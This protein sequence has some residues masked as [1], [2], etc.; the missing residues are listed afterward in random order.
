[1]R[2]LRAT[3]RENLHSNKDPA[4]SK[5]NIQILIIKKK[6]PMQSCDQGT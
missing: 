1:M 2:S 5:I 3:T 6:L 4:Q